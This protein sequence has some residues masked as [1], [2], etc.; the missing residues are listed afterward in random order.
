MNENRENSLIKFAENIWYHYKWAIMIVSF[1]V[2]VL[3]VCITQQ[4]SNKKPDVFIYHV[5]SAGLTAT[6]VENLRDC[7]S[8]FAVD[9]NGDGVVNVDY[10]E[11]IYIADTISVAGGQLS[12]TDSF[13]LELFAGECVIYIMDESFYKGNSDY[14]VSIE[15]ILGYLPDGAYDDKALLL[16]ELPAYKT[17]PGLCDLPRESFI[18]VRKKRIGLNEM[19]SKDYD[20][21]LDYFRKFVEFLT[22]VPVEAE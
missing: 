21:N 6:S 2:V 12:V 20:N 3:V 16:S 19:D 15:D 4:M 18:C 7:L 1:F 5:S 10:K 14:M 13:N 8:G 22:Y 17:A 9:Y 11:E